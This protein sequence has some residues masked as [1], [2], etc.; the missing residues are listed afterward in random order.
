MRDR[1]EHHSRRLEKGGGGEGLTRDTHMVEA[2]AELPFELKFHLH[3]VF[4]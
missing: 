4:M 1:L 2:D 3:H